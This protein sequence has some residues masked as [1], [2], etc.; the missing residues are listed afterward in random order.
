MFK[1]ENLPPYSY[2]FRGRRFCSIPGNWSKVPL[3]TCWYR[4][5][6]HCICSSSPKSTSYLSQTL[7][8]CSS[9]CAWLFCELSP[10]PSGDGSHQSSLGCWIWRGPQLLGT[11]RS[12]W[13]WSTGR[14]FCW[15]PFPRHHHCSGQSA[16]EE[17]NLDWPGTSI[18]LGSTS[19]SASPLLRSY[20]D[21]HPC[22]PSTRFCRSVL[23]A[24]VPTSSFFFRGYFPRCFG[25][26]CSFSLF[27][28][29]F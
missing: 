19:P 26:V 13:V 21:S 2:I 15:P 4:G 6:L 27:T 10:N 3:R 18:N 12:L 16:P 7:P 11:S 17:W 1:D 22:H 28:W 23:L 20:L 8:H 14:L 24:W 25:L 5:P 29:F 9:C